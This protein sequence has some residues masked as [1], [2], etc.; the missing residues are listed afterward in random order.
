MD[1]RADWIRRANALH[2]ADRTLTRQDV[3][4]QLKDAGHSRPTG[5]ENN[6]FRGPKLA[7]YPV[8]GSKT[9][10]PG[11]TQRRKEHEKTSTPEAQDALEQ[12]QSW[13]AT[14]NN[15]AA[16]NGVEGANLEH[17][18][19]SDHAAE[20]IQDR[21]RAGDYTYLNPDSEAAWKTA[22]EDFIRTKRGNN[23]RLLNG[24]DTYRLV[25]ER[26]ADDLV[27]PYDLP[28]MDIDPS[29]KPE[30]IFSALPF[31]VAQDLSMKQTQFP[32]QGPLPGLTTTAGKA[33]WKPPALPGYD[34]SEEP[35]PAVTAP[36]GGGYVAP[37]VME[38]SDQKVDYTAQNTAQLMDLGRKVTDARLLIRAG[39][40][41]WNGAQALG[42]VFG[43]GAASP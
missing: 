36:Q 10:S 19:A 23:Y 2:K 15:M 12:L 41:I 9:R 7:R 30:Q 43:A 26:Y 4:K 24:A 22:M 27:D 35:G 33:Q 14:M 11:Q 42:A 5:V 38:S 28:G 32:G 13:Q 6:G 25:D 40:V 29:M 8:W 21:G 1:I 20:V 3:V 34:M 37:Q 39:K 31:I 17:A 18:Y 16:A